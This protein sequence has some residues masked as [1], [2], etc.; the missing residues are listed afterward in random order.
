[1]YESFFNMK[2]EPFG[3]TPN[4]RFLFLSKKHEEALASLSYGINKRKGFILITGEIGTGKTTIC[5][6][7]LNRLKDIDSALILNPSLTEGGLLT[8][9]VD[10][11]GLTSGRS[12]KEKID[13]LN[14]FLL[15]RREAGRNAVVIIDE[16]QHLS[17]KALEMVRLLSNLETEREKL[18]Q[19]VFMGQPELREKLENKELKQL[20]QRIVVRYHLNPLD[21]EETFDYILH[22]LKVAGCP[23]GFLTFTNGAA[24]RVFRH[25]KGYPRLINVLCDRVLT[26]AYVENK[27][28]VDKEMVLKAI[29]DIEGYKSSVHN[30]WG[31]H[32]L[33]GIFRRR[34]TVL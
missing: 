4:P 28:V 17:I 33:L 32:R 8:A 30:T 23:E 18:I 21:C 20:N 25:T 13:T 14:R 24:D 5:R 26:A 1:M 34:G 10:D 29:K 19:I 15:E 16:S 31:F 6:E 2:E 7:L 12:I 22:R 11:F 3:M 27:K 9:I